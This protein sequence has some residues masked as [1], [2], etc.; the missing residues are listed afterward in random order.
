LPDVTARPDGTL[1]LI[2][3]A[4][5]LGQLE[6]HAKPKLDIYAYV[7]QE[8][9]GRAAYTG[10]QSVRFSTTTLTGSGA[11]APVGTATT[12]TTSN[13][14]IGGYGS[15]FANNS[16]CST[17]NPPAT[18]LAPSA[19][20][21]CAGDIRAITEGTIG[22]WHKVYTGPKGGVR[23]GIQYSYITKTGWFGVNSISPKAVDNMLFTSFRYY[24]P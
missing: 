10:Y 11:G 14:G 21:T 1:A 22:F 23:W 17:E 3:S 19:G 24:I 9:G 5:W 12:I 2:K 20:G 18:Q 13:T 7:G 16:G 8:Y 4:Q 6:F 15:P